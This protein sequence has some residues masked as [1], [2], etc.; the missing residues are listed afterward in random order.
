MVWLIKDTKA[1]NGGGAET[2][3]KP[4]TV[5]KL[6]FAMWRPAPGLTVDRAGGAK[7]I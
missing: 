1:S 2:G 4:M 3:G 7:T 5:G 6:G